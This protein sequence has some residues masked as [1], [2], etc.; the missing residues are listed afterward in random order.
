M[1]FC[2]VLVV[3]RVVAKKL[4]SSEAVNQNGIHTGNLAEVANSS[5]CLK[6][7]IYSQ[8]KNFDINEIQATERVYEVM[9]M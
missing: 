1:V 6:Q 7:Q 9:F 4:Y 2:D 8:N 5:M 3:S